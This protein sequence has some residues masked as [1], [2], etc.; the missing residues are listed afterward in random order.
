ME[1][2]LGGWSS[3]WRSTPSGPAAAAIDQ[4]VLE[5]VIAAVDARLHEHAGQM[6]R[7]LA[8]LEA[9]FAV[10]VRALHQQDSQA[11]E[12]GAKHLAEIELRFRREADALRSAM[13]LELRKLAESVSHAVA[14]QAGTRA[15]L[16]ALHGQ[17]ER[18]VDAAE[19]R[20]ADMRIEYREALAGEA[21]AN[22]RRAAEIRAALEQSMEPRIAAAAAA[23]AAIEVERQLAPWRAEVLRKE[24]EVAALRRRLEDGEKSVLDVVAT[25]G[26]VCRQAASR[27]GGPSKPLPAD[28]PSGPRA[29]AIDSDEQAMPAIAEPMPPPA[30]AVETLPVPELAAD[31]AL[32]T[33]VPDF[34]RQPER[35]THWRIPLVSSL[36]VTTGCLLLM[37]YL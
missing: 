28:A 21:A 15:E 5:A 30:P 10:E 27:F 11:S 32:G 13:E 34:L 7:R 20:F 3:A 35:D 36:L 22:E 6:D 16:Q 37:H 2:R 12:S 23:A 31:P 17:N 19:Q 26:E 24:Q 4:K 1:R 29:P 14:G 9:R 33:A 8:D 25:I 18:L